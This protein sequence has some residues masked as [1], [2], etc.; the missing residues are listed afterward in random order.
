MNEV[1]ARGLEGGGFTSLEPAWGEGSGGGGS[2]H[3]RPL[4]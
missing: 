3:L 1:G 2:E 4:A